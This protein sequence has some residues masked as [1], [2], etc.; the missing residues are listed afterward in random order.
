MLN[1][2]LLKR[3]EAEWSDDSIRR[4]TQEL[5]HLIA[6]VWPVPADHRSGFALVRR[7]AGRG[8][9]FCVLVGL[10]P[11]SDRVIRKSDVMER[12]AP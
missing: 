11:S 3:A 4:R 9:S 10:I 7:R 5:A 8:T 6:D 2:E 12:D 1:R